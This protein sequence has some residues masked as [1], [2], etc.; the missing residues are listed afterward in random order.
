MT[1][2]AALSVAPTSSTA[3]NTNC[4]SLEP[5]TG[6]LVWTVAIVCLLGSGFGRP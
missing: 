2:S 6:G 4:S 3:L 1:T 5:S